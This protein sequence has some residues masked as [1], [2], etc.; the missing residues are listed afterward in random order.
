MEMDN[1]DCNNLKKMAYSFNKMACTTF[2]CDNMVAHQLLFDKMLF[3]L[4]VVADQILKICAEDTDFEVDLEV[5][6]EMT[7]LKEWIPDL[8]S[9]LLVIEKQVEKVWAVY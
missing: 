3:E 1:F 2:V 6:T 4:L 7:D 5:V 8:K 9:L